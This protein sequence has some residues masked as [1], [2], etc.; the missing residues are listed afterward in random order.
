MKR[1]QNNEQINLTDFILTKLNMLKKNIKY[2]HCTIYDLFIYYVCMYNI[3]IY[4]F[5]LY[6][7][8]F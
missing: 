5:Y 4:N 2:I 6:V 8:V 3:C 1:W 7:Y